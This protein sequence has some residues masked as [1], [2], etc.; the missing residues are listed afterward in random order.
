[1]KKTIYLQR[2]NKVIVNKE[3]TTLPD[4]YVATVL[5]NIEQLG[6]TF[7]QELIETVR[8]LSLDSFKTFY[9]ALVTDLKKKVGAHVKHEPMYPNFPEEVMEANEVDLYV[10]AILHYLTLALPVKEAKERFPLL[11]RVDLK[12]I[13][14]GSDED[15]DLMMKQLMGANGSLSET[16]KEHIA[17]ALHTYEDVSVILPSEIPIKENV[18]FVVGTLL[19]ADKISVQQVYPYF[20]TATDVLRFATSLSEGDV[21]LATNTRFKK[22]KRAERRLLLGLLENCGNITEDMIRYKKRWIRLGEI[23]HPSEYK[24]KYSKTQEAF[25]ILRNNK[26]YKTFGSRVENALLTKDVATAINLLQKRPGEFARRL[27]HLFRMG[28][29]AAIVKAFGD[30]SENVATP[31]LLQ[32]LGHFKGR[33]KAKEVRAFFPKGNVAN[34]VAIKNELPL[35]SQETC[36]SIVSAIEE[37]LVKRFAELPSLG[38]VT[39]DEQL[40]NYLVPFSQRSASKA[41]RTIVRGSQLDMPKGD[42]IRFFLWWKEGKVNGEH[43]GRVDID[44]SAVMY[45]ENWEYKEHVSYTNLRS[46]SYKAYHSG[47]I[48]SAPNGACEFIDLDIPSVLEHGGR[49]IVTSLNSFTHQPF[50][51]IP[52]CFAGWMVR[53][54]PNSGEIFEPSTVQDK[55]DLA[56]NTTVSIPVI[57]DLQER[58]VIWCDLA[59]NHYPDYHGNGRGYGA[60]NVENVQKGMVAMGKAMTTLSKPSLYDLFS[61]HV[62]AR[63]ELVAN[64][65]ELEEGDEIN[66][67]FSVNEG[68]TPFE[69]EKI[70]AEFML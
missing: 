68:V 20:K 64:I 9:T 19:K 22:F 58:K 30:V 17:W 6:F 29:H 32:L 44:L 43:T 11:E 67:V 27:D 41:L 16:D 13:D 26:P 18:A 15:F 36:D 12:V 48:T 24:N 69:I 42:T 40:K 52:E 70:M 61:L 59:L 21:S 46:S 45:D 14:L 34:A 10:N 35:L 8:T 56:S 51:T 39:L 4:V 63:G 57:L 28:N 33:T 38:K 65:E 25:S 49:Y 60:N 47:D 31:V 53:K 50:D 37:T 62:K 3:E 5:K 7:S 54:E 2:K 1:M 66:T 23:L 55:I